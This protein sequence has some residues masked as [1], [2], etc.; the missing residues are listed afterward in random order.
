[1]QCAKRPP[2]FVLQAFIESFSRFIVMREKSEITILRRE[3]WV[4]DGVA[5][6]YGS[7]SELRA[8]L[9][10]DFSQEKFQL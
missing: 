3:E 1:M 2:D 8:T 10:Y 6:V 5:V 9:E 7:A 4:L